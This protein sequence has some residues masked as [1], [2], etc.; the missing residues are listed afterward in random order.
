MLRGPF[1]ASESAVAVTLLCMGWVG[2][3]VYSW[4]SRW[5][6]GPAIHLDR[7]PA[8]AQRFVVDI[9]QASREE[10]AVLPGLGPKLAEA[11]I[12]YRQERGGFRNLEELLEVPGVGPAKLALFRPFLA[13]QNAET[14]HLHSPDSPGVGPPERE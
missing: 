12:G 7:A 2:I 10:L 5:R 8:I 4:G 1:L 3:L 13:L 14:G 9:N 11:I 6:D